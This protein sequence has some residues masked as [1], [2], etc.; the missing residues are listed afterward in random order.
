MKKAYALVEVEGA[1]ETIFYGGR[2]YTE[3][4]K[5]LF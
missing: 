3:I 2:T 4:E 5:Y 1:N